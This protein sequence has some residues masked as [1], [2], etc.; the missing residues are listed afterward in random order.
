MLWKESAFRAP[1][2]S[3]YPTHAAVGMV[4]DGK[5]GLIY[6]ATIY[7]QVNSTRVLKEMEAE[8]RETVGLENGAQEPAKKAKFLRRLGQMGDPRSLKIFTRRL[9][10]MVDPVVRGAA[11]DSMFLNDPVRAA[12]WMEKHKD[13]LD[14]ARRDEDYREALPYVLTL[15][16]LKWNDRIKGPADRELAFVRRLAQFELEAALAKV[17]SGDAAA[18]REQLEAVVARFPGLKAAKRAA[19]KL[20]ELPSLEAE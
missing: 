3:E 13:L 18:A 2:L 10:R 9:G 15:A 12:A 6:S 19:E 17:E 4:R 5:G 1:V 14:K 8:Y 11:L 20:A 7:V 16:R